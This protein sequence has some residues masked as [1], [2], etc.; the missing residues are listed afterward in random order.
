MQTR[1][2]VYG[3]TLAL[4][5]LALPANASAAE[6]Y[7]RSSGTMRAGAGSD[8]P[9]IMHVARGTGLEIY[10]CTRRYAWCDVSADGERGWFPG[11]RIDFDR[12]GRRIRLSEGAG[13]LGLTILTFGMADYWGSHY[14]DR[15]WYGQSRWWRGHG[16]QAPQRGGDGPRGDGNDQG[17]RPSPDRSRTPS[18]DA[19]RPRTHETAPVVREKPP[20]ARD[21]TPDFAAPRAVHTPDR[22][23]PRRQVERPSPRGDGAAHGNAPHREMPTQGKQPGGGPRLIPP[24]EQGR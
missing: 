10:G 13:A 6:G 16:L 12:D 18:A 17:T 2:I 4:G 22:A 5:V 9:T 21:R 11:S 7:A 8:Y 14:S 20:A 1:S 3:L 23:A 15:S 19:P 24:V